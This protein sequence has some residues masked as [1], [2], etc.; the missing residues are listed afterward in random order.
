MSAD[1]LNS[2][3]QGWSKPLKECQ[4]LGQKLKVEQMY[5][6]IC[7]VCASV[8][9]KLVEVVEMVDNLIHVEWC[10]EYLQSIPSSRGEDFPEW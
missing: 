10:E 4:N 3:F 8:A 2:Q 1:I 5:C 9:I 7:E 6:L